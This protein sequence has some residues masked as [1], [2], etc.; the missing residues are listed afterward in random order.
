MMNL[1]FVRRMVGNGQAG[2]RERMITLTPDLLLHRQRL[3]VV[4]CPSDKC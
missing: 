2:G 1:S 4:L 3:P